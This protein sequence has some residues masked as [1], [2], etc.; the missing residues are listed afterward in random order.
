[1]LDG[2]KI[3]VERLEAY[4]GDGIEQFDYLAQ[5]VVRNY[6][7]DV[8]P[9]T[10]EEKASVR[11]ALIKYRRKQFTARVLNRVS[12]ESEQIEGFGE[13]RLIKPQRIIVN[14]AQME[15]ARRLVK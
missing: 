12:G 2:I 10:D 3:L 1:M 11:E 4:E 6:G 15:V 7:D 9:F 14:K 8:D 5:E 13:A